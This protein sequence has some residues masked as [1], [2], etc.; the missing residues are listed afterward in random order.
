MEFEQ[1]GLFQERDEGFFLLFGA[2]RRR[3]VPYIDTPPTPPK[4]G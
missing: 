4:V 2:K 1:V 3:N